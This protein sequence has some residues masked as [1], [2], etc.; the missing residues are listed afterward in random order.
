MEEGERLR[1]EMESVIASSAWLTAWSAVSP[2]SS[3]GSILGK[4][5]LLVPNWLR[6]TRL[7]VGVGFGADVG[8][9]FGAPV[10]LFFSWAK[11]SFSFIIADLIFPNLRRKV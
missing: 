3:K 11:R 1:D 2:Q 9:G 8:L 5:K 7:T 4:K 10:I 6:K